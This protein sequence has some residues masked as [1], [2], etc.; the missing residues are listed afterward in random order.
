MGGAAWE[1]HA[2][3]HPRRLRGVRT[4]RA[5]A[6]GHW[7]G[8]R[9]TEGLTPVRVRP[10]PN[11]LPQHG[12]TGL[13][14]RPSEVCRAAN[15]RSPEVIR[16]SRNL[17]VDRTW[18]ILHS[19]LGQ[20]NAIKGK[21]LAVMVGLRADK[22]GERAVQKAV[23]VLRKQ[24]RPIAAGDAGYYVPILASEKKAY[25]ESIKSRVATMCVAYRKAAAAMEI[26][27]VEQMPL[28]S[29]PEGRDTA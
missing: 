21:D 13:R 8:K 27:P 9:E 5:R 10:P 24:G 7:C 16:L 2:C 29:G 28:F 25:L 23:E 1:A 15:N 22:T 18:D 17:I 19:R 14:D 20:R 12:D 4:A 3:T 6:S 11:S 26:P